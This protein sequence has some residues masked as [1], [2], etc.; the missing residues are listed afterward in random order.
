MDAVQATG[1]D[2]GA[3]DI[4]AATL[5][6][7]GV[8]VIVFEKRSEHLLCLGSDTFLCSKMARALVVTRVPVTMSWFVKVV[9]D[10]RNTKN[11]QTVGNDIVQC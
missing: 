3:D 9:P 1:V 7:L 2:I 8:G 10:D 5:Y 4:D 11:R 6:Q